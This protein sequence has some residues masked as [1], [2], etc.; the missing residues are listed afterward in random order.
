MADLVHLIIYELN[1]EAKKC[2]LKNMSERAKEL[3]NKEIIRLKE[4]EKRINIFFN[5]SIK[6]G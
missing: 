6:E 4:T 5:E 1:E 3:L 2:I